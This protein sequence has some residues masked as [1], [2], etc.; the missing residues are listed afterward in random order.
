MLLSFSM[1]NLGPFKDKVTLSMVPGKISKQHPNHIIQTTMYSALKGAAIYGANAS[2]KSWLAMGLFLLKRS[3]IDNNNPSI[4]L[5]NRFRLDDTKSNAEFEINFQI[6]D[7]AYRYFVSTDGMEVFEE[8]LYVLQKYGEDKLIFNRKEM[9]VEFGS[10]LKPSLDWYK[11]RTFKKNSFF[12]SEVEKA[13]IFDNAKTIAGSN[14]FIAL[15]RFLS[16]LIGIHPQWIVPYEHL[17]K[18]NL[19]EYGTFLEDLLKQA[20]IGISNINLEK[21]SLEKTTDLWRQYLAQFPQANNYLLPESAIFVRAMDGYYFILFEN[22]QVQAYRLKTV[23]NGIEFD[24]TMESS[25][26]LR[27]IEI[28]LY[29]YKLQKDPDFCLII[30]ELDCR[31]HPFLSKMLLQRHL[32]N[33]AI[34]SQLI[35]TLHDFYLMDGKIWRSDEIWFTEKKVDQSADVYSLYQFTPRFDKNLQEGYK[36]GKYGAIPMIGDFND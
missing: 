10:V 9:N 1:S 13:G 2:G 36:Q 18:F 28:G 32:E 14:Y 3:I 24:I 15:L 21:V 33:S 22:G 20:D 6:D 5:N 26:T 8:A 11:N 29:F 12:V 17:I 25:G 30:D 31:L 34:R 16:Q 7:V 19:N 35:V 27:L 4:I 23:H